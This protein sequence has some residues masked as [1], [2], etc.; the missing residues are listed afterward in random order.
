MDL[1]ILSQCPFTLGKAS[2]QEPMEVL[3]LCL[4]SFLGMFSLLSYRLST[5]ITSH[6]HYSL[7]FLLVLNEEI[8]C[9][10]CSS[11]VLLISQDVNFL[12]FVLEKRNI[13][14]CILSE[15]E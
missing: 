13:T 8:V 5:S 4:L 15:T 2:C 7:N 12:Y 6:V 3:V 10:S 1:C 14:F 9:S 11:H